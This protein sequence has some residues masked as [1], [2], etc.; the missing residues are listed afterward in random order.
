MWLF[1]RSHA[2]LG[3]NWSVGL[4]VQQNHQLVQHGV[5]R[6]VRHPMYAAFLL[7]GLAQAV[8]LPNAVAG[9]S[10]LLAVLL[11]CFARIPRE[12]AMMCQAFGPEYKSYMQTTG[13]V[14]PSL[15]RRR[16]A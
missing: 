9:P 8:L 15:L 10:A 16:A 2:D 7:F 12:E 11:L 4:E 14:V 3:K 6:L 1:W 5:Y 13:S